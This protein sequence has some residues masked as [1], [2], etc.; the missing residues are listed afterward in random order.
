MTPK[1]SDLVLST[2]I[3]Y[4]EFDIL[5][6]DRFDVEAYRRDGCDGLIEFEFVEDRG[7]SCC[8][9][10]KHENTHFFVAKD[11]AHGFAEG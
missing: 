6:L 2:H 1:R 3:P 5:V 7:F 11:F 4:V 8:V 10:T 9:E